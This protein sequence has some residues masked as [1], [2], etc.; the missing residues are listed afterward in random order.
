MS[1]PTCAS[2]GCRFA[3]L[4]KFG[5]L[6]C[7]PCWEM[8]ANAVQRGTGSLAVLLGQSVDPSAT[9]RVP[10]F[11]ARETVAVPS[12]QTSSQAS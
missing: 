3:K 6:V 8:H 1:V 11:V 9:Q 4:L 5:E 10:V 7:R 2:C 12:L